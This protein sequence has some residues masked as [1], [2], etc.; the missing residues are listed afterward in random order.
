L[1]QL[2]LVAL[3]AAGTW[4]L[5]IGTLILMYWQTHLAQKLNSA[6]AVLALRERYDSPQIRRARRALATTLLED[7]SSAF[8]RAELLTFF[9]LLGVMTHRKLL[10][11]ELVWNSFGG[12]VSSYHVVQRI[13]RRR[14][15]P[16]QAN[17]IEAEEESRAI[18]RHESELPLE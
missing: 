1:S 17:V 11:R 5:V 8:P 13:D 15:G 4:V 7:T 3:T 2:D 14:L 12:W 16:A 10:D 18:L 9:E 6:N